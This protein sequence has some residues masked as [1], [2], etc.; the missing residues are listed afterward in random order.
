LWIDALCINQADDEE[1]NHQ[2]A[3]MAR[4][5]SSAGLV[6]I[7]IS[8]VLGYRKEE[9]EE[10][11]KE[12]F[13]FFDA[14]WNSSWGEPSYAHLSGRGLQAVLKGIRLIDS[15]TYWTRTWIIQEVVMAP[16][17][18]LHFG[19]YTFA[20]DRLI[21][22]WNL[23]PFPRIISG[24]DLP[25]RIDIERKKRARGL[26]S[27]LFELFQL[28]QNSECYNPRD[29][30]YS[31]LGLVENAPI[32]AD[33]SMPVADVYKNLLA[34]PEVQFLAPEIAARRHNLREEETQ[35]VFKSF[36]H[37]LHLTVES[38]ARTCVYSGQPWTE[39]GALEK[40]I[41]H[42]AH[43][44]EQH[45]DLTF[46]LDI[47][48][49]IVGMSGRYKDSVPRFLRSRFMKA[50]KDG[51]S[52]T[53]D[54]KALPERWGPQTQDLLREYSLFIDD[55]GTIGLSQRTIKVGD[56]ACQLGDS[57]LVVFVD[58]KLNVGGSGHDL[59]KIEYGVVEGL[60]HK[61][62]SS[63]LRRGPDT[64]Y[65]KPLRLD[66]P[67]IKVFNGYRSP[68]HELDFPLRRTS[69]GRENQKGLLIRRKEGRG[70]R[71]SHKG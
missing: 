14:A 55:W 44:T 11:F 1:R 3:Q 66:V 36:L 63:I 8:P 59:K 65:K 29:R 46:Q 41:A 70:E 12:L 43:R 51:E 32:I 53:V 52:A 49:A 31:L 25:R 68:H 48:S 61:A 24:D 23:L 71:G 15:S 40:F 50:L 54:P 9:V 2:V 62:L 56:L 4:I 39:K 35:L 45:G 33:Y 19:Q 17:L 16:S 22:M 67:S 27:T 47:R 37:D 7:W 60:L 69:F 30:I 42:L 13:A 5:Y 18:I 26:Q 34:L 57:D 58:Q 21:Y 10:I 38:Q 64:A 28:S 20:W 6:V